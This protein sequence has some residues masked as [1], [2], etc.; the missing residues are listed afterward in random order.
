MFVRRFDAFDN[1]TFS[2]SRLS[3]LGEPIPGALWYATFELFSSQVRIRRCGCLFRPL[4]QASTFRIE[5][6]DTEGRHMPRLQPQ[7][8]R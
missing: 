2:C 6:K 7:P 1:L 5:R 4:S 3:G 8:L